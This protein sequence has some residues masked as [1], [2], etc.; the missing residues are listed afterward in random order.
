MKKRII[1]ILLVITQ[2]LTIIPVVAFGAGDKVTPF[3]DVEKDSVYAEGIEF[4]HELGVV[5]GDLEG[6]FRPSDNVNRSELAKMLYIVLN[7]TEKPAATESKYTDVAINYWYNPYA[8]WVTSKRLILPAATDKFA[9]KGEVTVEELAKIIV[10]IVEGK[11]LANGYESFTDK[12]AA[13]GLFGEA[14][15]PEKDSPA[16]RELAAFVLYNILELDC[17]FLDGATPI[18]AGFPELLEVASTKNMMLVSTYTNNVGINDG[19]DDYDGVHSVDLKS[20]SLAELGLSTYTDT[21]KTAK[22][23]KYYGRES[24]DDLVGLPVTVSFDKNGNVLGAE[25]FGTAVTCNA[26]DL[27]TKFG[28]YYIGDTQIRMDWNRFNFDSSHN[29]PRLYTIQGNLTYISNW[30]GANRLFDTYTDERV[31]LVDTDKNGKYDWMLCIPIWNGLEIKSIEEGIL[32]TSNNPVGS[33]QY[34]GWPMNPNKFE[35]DDVIKVGDYV[36]IRYKSDGTAGN[37]IADRN[38]APLYN[39]AYVTKA[40]V[41]TGKLERINKVSSFI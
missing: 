2:I 5:S 8:N 36:N 28:Q 18:V 4:L 25:L 14:E 13:L 9:P 34:T 7:G 15:K 33:W 12:V 6:N 17:E 38:G 26:G 29:S 41:V 35:T 20:I 1:S 11:P 22:N 3:P 40:E 19:T 32:T 37:K 10:T 24:I 21:L 31:T 23:Y 27:V 30:S 39:Y 16:T